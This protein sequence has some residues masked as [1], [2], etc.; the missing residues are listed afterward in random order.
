VPVAGEVLDEPQPRQL[1][2]TVYG[3]YARDAEGWLPVAGLVRLLGEL[4]IGPQAVRSSIS[5]LKRRDALRSVRRCGA[6]G[7]SL[8]PSMAEILGEGDRR[9]FGHLP[10]RLADGWVQVVFTV[11][12]AQRGKRHELRSRLAGLGFGPMAPGVWVAPGTRADEVRVALAR[13]GLTGFVDLFRGQYLAGEEFGYPPL[14]QRVREWWDLAEIEARYAA[15]VADH[16]PLAR[17][18]ARRE[19]SPGE[20]FAAYVRMLTVWRR[21]RYLDPGLPLELLPDRWTG[22]AAAELFDQLDAALRPVAEE[23]AATVIRTAT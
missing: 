11:P 2:V 10:A 5:R 12:E 17:R 4:G 16:R 7:Y 22:V 19:P 8:A 14:A 15:F 1:I 23:H 21:L 6:A 3:L 13:Q 20:A 9:I 18:V